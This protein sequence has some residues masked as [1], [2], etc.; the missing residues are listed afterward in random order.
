MMIKLW[1]MKKNNMLS[2]N[3]SLQLLILRKN[4]PSLNQKSL[5]HK[6]LISTSPNAK[7]T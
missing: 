6:L 3:L 5:N 1:E 4:Q 7:V 2:L